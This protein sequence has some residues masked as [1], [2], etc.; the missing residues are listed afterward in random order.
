MGLSFVSKVAPSRFQG[1]MQ[2]GWLLATA[3]GNKL[4]FVGTLLWDKVD[5]TLLWLVFIICCLLSA[6]F[7]F[8]ILKRLEKASAG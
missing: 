2:G 8:T 3:V 5:L 1:L 6:G 4:L 7:I